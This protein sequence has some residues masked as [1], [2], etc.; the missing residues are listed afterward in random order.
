MVSN[1]A[2]NLLF[3]RALG[4]GQS[5]VVRRDRFKSNVFGSDQFASLNVPLGQPVEP[6]P[7]PTRTRSTV[8]ENRCSSASSP[9]QSLT[10][11]CKPISARSDFQNPRDQS[12]AALAAGLTHDRL[13]MSF[14]GKSSLRG[15]KEKDVGG[16]SIDDLGPG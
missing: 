14:A 7:R 8:N 2:L 12:T 6:D 9:A 5:V 11:D 16:A 4:H 10:S 1:H 13:A 3:K 15:V